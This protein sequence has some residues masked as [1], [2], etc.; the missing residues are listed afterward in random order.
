MTR[1]LLI[2]GL[3]IQAKA[4]LD[5][6]KHLDHVVP[7]IFT[8]GKKRNTVLACVLVLCASLGLVFITCLHHMSS[9]CAMEL[10]EHYST[11]HPTNTP[12]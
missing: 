4:N 2:S 1:I 9:R 7:G 10:T 11:T 6:I 12:S 8:Q 5:V 3:P